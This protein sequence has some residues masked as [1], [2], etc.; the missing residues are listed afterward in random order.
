MQYLGFI[1]CQGALII[2]NRRTSTILEMLIFFFCVDSL[3]VSCPPSYMTC[4]VLF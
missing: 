4:L 1:H 2:V 3:V